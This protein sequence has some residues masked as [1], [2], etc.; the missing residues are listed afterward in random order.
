VLTEVN[1]FT[2]RYY[3]KD[4]VVTTLAPDQYPQAIEAEIDINGSG[5][6]TRLLL[7]PEKRRN[8][9]TP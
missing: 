8:G 7:L 5:T 3:L 6:I 1:A 9:G 4:A 2:L